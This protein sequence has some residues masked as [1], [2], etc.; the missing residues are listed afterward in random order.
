MTRRSTIGDNPLDSIGSPSSAVKSGLPAGDEPGPPK[1]RARSARAANPDAEPETPQSDPG[2]VGLRW[3]YL[4][5]RLRRIRIVG[6]DTPPGVT[7]L[8]PARPH[9]PCHF[10][11]PSGEV[12]DL[13]RDVVSVDVQTEDTTR[14]IDSLLVWATVGAFF[15]GP[16]GALAGS[17]YGGRERRSTAL[18][19]HLHDGRHV[20]AVTD[21]ETAQEMQ[22]ELR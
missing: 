2:A 20:L 12:I 18:D 6:G 10:S 4:P 1:S 3:P 21:R 7:R 17:L 9:E 14:R 22:G 19:I 16:L 13:K 15:V 5:F 8:S 11:L